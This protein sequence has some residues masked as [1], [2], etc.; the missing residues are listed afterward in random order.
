M[1]VRRLG[2]DDAPALHAMRR[3]ALERHPFAFSSS[4]EEDRFRTLEAVVAALEPAP[5]RAVLGAFDGGTLIAMGGLMRQPRAKH[6]HKAGIWGIYVSPAARGRGAGR[7]L[8]DALVGEARRWKGVVKVELSVTAEA[9]DAH[10]LYESA[11]FRVWGT[12]PRSL[13]RDGRFV[14]E[15]YMSLDLDGGA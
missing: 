12:E 13:G 10:R 9:P 3:E 4:P 15:I 2:V 7:L 11:G 14:D 8:L 1:T 6:R 5:G